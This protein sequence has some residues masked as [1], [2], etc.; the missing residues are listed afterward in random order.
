MSRTLPG[1]RGERTH[2]TRQQAGNKAAPA[3]TSPKP[4]TGGNHG[5]DHNQTS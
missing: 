5:S 2:S 1:S 3:T 4:I